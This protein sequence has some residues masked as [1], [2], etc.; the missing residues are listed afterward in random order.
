MLLCQ[1]EINGQDQSYAPTTIQENHQSLILLNRAHSECETLHQTTKMRNHVVEDQ[2]FPH[3]RR[4][5]FNFSFAVVT[6]E[7]ERRTLSSSFKTK[8]SRQA[9]DS[10]FKRTKRCVPLK[11]FPQIHAMPSQMKTNTPDSLQSL[12]LKPANKNLQGT[13]TN[14]KEQHTSQTIADH[15]HTI[16]Q[17]QLILNK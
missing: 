11:A 7:L 13:T 9:R 12:K 5:Q 1:D 8:Q 16:I 14:R 17:V 6:L 2:E 10:S 15:V 3:E 4:P